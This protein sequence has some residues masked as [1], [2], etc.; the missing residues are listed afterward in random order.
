[1]KS[2]VGLLIAICIVTIKTTFSESDNGLIIFGNFDYY[3]LHKRNYQPEEVNYNY[4]FSK[5]FESNIE[6]E[7]PIIPSIPP[8]P[9]TPTIIP[10]PPIPG[11]NDN[12]SIGGSGSGSGGSG[13]SGSGSGSG[14]SGGS[15]SGSGSGDI[16]YNGMYL[17]DNNK[18]LP[19]TYHLSEGDIIVAGETNGLYNGM[20]STKLGYQMRNVNNI[21][22]SG[23]SSYS[24]NGMLSLGGEI[25]NDGSITVNGTSNFNNIG[26]LVSNAGGIG[27]NASLITVN[28]NQIGMYGTSGTTI[29]N[30]N[31]AININSGIGMITRGA[32]AQAI[33]YNG[34][35][36]GSNSTGM[37]SYEGAVATNKSEVTLKG[38]SSIGMSAISS[39]NAINDGFIS[40]S[41]SQYGMF[42]SDGSTIKNTNTLN[43]INGGIGA[44]VDNNS[45]KST[46]ENASNSTIDVYSGGIGVYLAG[47]G[48]AVN[49]G[50][51]SL[52]DG[53]GIYAYN[54]SE[55]INKSQITANQ[56]STAMVAREASRIINEATITLAGTSSIGM[57]ADKTS[58]AINS[59]KITLSDS[60]Q[61]GMYATG[62][63]TLTTTIS[64]NISVSMG[65]GILVSGPGGATNSG[66][67]SVT[68]S[69]NGMYIKNSGTITNDGQIYVNDSNTNAMGSS[70]NQTILVNATNGVITIEDSVSNS[71]AFNMNG[72]VAQNSG[73]LNLGTTGIAATGGTIY[74][75]GI[76][77]GIATSNNYYVPENYELVMEKG[78]NIGGAKLQEAII[79]LSYAQA[80]FTKN[81]TDG[82]LLNLS[83][84]ADNFVSHSYLYDI[85]TENGDS[86]IKRKRFTEL[87]NSSIGEY[88]EN[89]YNLENEESK[90]KMYSALRSIRSQAEFDK[91]LDLFFGRDFYPTVIFQT[92]DSINFTTNNILDNLET[93]YNTD[94][95][96]SY[97]V[98]YSLERTKQKNL[99]NQ[100]GFDEY[101]NGFYL[102]KQY[103]LNE[104]SNYGFLFSYT[105]LD[106]DY[107]SNRG[108]RKDNFFQE[109]SFLNYAKDN[110]KG[111]GVL[112]FGYAQGNLKR[113]LNV[114][115]L[116]NNGTSIE[117]VSLDESF[118]SDIKNLYVGTSGKISKEYKFDTF[119][120]EPEM[121]GYLMGVFQ[122]EI[123]EAGGEYAINLDN[124]NK[125]FSTIK[126]G[127]SIGKIFY[128]KDNYKL[129][130]KLKGGV[131]QDINSANENLNL[132]LK[133]LSNETTD[134]KVDRKNQF[135]KEVGTRIDLSKDTI[136]DE[137]TL[138]VEYKYI[139]E[140]K[141][142]WKTSAGFIYTF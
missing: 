106:S 44:Y 57:Y 64:S 95:D 88:L 32:N 129:T 132:K 112:Y 120:V 9:E 46:F 123:K 37:V 45:N 7:T 78:G 67:I 35:N 2:K 1:M 69:G 108:K 97:I 89:I 126:I 33:N 84:K 55:A 19:G 62:N 86:Y 73:V 65:T 28:N 85:Y 5:E 68:N 11:I 128:P 53:I 26:M 87:T 3:R 80:L 79:G 25:Y 130:L 77:N 18:W 39:G 100:I 83:V 124:M 101:L 43:A 125:V 117:Y 14:D 140:D 92:R 98:G 90:I 103:T 10:I 58:T 137:L 104:N 6:P 48:Y 22:I 72:G 110:I 49:N 111:I 119:F 15:G 59:G 56:G 94:K 17:F 63:S 96:N 36:V 66:V 41:N 20:G 99:S 76:I 116:E 51:M 52:T 47:N 50:F 82:F 142:S 12:G 75:W 74:N 122:K 133:N 31:G 118:N 40:A 71:H 70:G 113:N 93:R 131:G 102:G 81:D 136:K 135:Y 60:G 54:N 21:T 107:N 24:L 4:K 34:I 134:I 16:S 61:I 30:Q 27:I 138:Y 115:F 91:D 23:T 127:T 42:A 8:S 13:G 121:K 141:N 105:R 114:S 29:S 109:T 139:F 38:S